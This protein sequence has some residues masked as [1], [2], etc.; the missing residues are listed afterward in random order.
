MYDSSGVNWLSH[1][2]HGTSRIVQL[3]GPGQHIRGAGR[4]FFLTFRVFEICRALIY[5]E[6]T[7]LSQQVWRDMMKNMWTGEHDIEWHPKETLFDLMISISSL[8]TR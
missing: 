8:N 3:R 6:E 2:M 1:M 7:F 5:A 4:K